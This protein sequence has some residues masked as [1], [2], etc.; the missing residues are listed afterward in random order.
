[1]QRARLLPP[2]ALDLLYLLAVLRQ[3]SYFSTSEARKLSTHLLAMLRDAA[4]NA[5]LHE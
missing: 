5:P 1:L 2:R 3:Y 4:A